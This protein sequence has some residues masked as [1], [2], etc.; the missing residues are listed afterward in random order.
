MPDVLI[1]NVPEE[2][3]EALRRRAARH[4]RSLQQELLRVLEDS[5]A[6]SRRD[7]AR[8]AAAI[9]RRLA[10]GRH[11]FDDGTPPVREDRGRSAARGA[12]PPRYGSAP[13]ARACAHS[14]AWVGP[15]APSVILDARCAQSPD[16]TSR[17][18]ASRSPATAHQLW[19][20]ST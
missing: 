19:C 13:A 4:G 12:S 20:C 15:I 14:H 9:R 10:A 6:R 8:V 17:Y 1:R 16:R 11:T 2:T 18:T 7:P 3:L 5:A